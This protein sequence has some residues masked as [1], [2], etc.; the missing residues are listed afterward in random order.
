MALK[1]YSSRIKILKFIYCDFQKGSNQV[2]NRNHNKK[3][4]LKNYCDN[5]LLQVKPLGKAIPRI[6][7]P[8]PLA[9]RA[10]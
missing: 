7:S 1:G 3:I 4:I 5:F 6:T 8:Q 9:S 2:P 10:D